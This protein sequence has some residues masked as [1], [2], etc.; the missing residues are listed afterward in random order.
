M[1]NDDLNAP[2][3]NPLPPVVIFLCCLVGGIELIFQAAEAGF[4]GGPEAI[5]WR[6]AAVQ[7]YAF[8]DPLFD[9]MRENGVY[10][11]HNMLRFVTYTFIHQSMMH[12]L[13][14]L[15]FLLALGKY[16]A[17]IMHP[18]AVL[19]IF[20]TSAAVGAMVYS[21]AFDEK[22]ALIGA[23]PAIYGL[24]GAYTWLGFSSLKSQGKDGFPAFNLIIFFTAIMLIFKLIFGGMNDW[25]AELV[26]F[27]VGFVLA[28]VL[29]PNGMQRV[30][31]ML[32]LARQR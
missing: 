27:C 5:G 1:Y 6:V 32:K 11:G 16:V 15:V 23:Y 28:V 8:S 24:I 31:A 9:W 10:S 22:F 13:F 26:G 2:P 20:F 21:I 14:A 29:S 12:A 25:F 19:V 3:I 7:Q 18:V 4:I 30:Q 17:E